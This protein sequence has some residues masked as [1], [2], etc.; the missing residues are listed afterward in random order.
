MKIINNILI[1]AFLLSGTAWAG[2][3]I[4]KQHQFYIEKPYGWSEVA[5]NKS[6][7]FSIG[8][9]AHN[10]EMGIIL[11]PLSGFGQMRMNQFSNH[12]MSGLYENSTVFKTYKNKLSKAGEVEFWEMS[13][14]ESGKDIY[15]IWAWKVNGMYYMM[16]GKSHDHDQKNLSVAM[17]NIFT[18]FF[19]TAQVKNDGYS[20]TAGR[21]SGRSHYVNSTEFRLD[22]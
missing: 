18:Q 12:I 21:S 14:Q 1:A 17:K 11:M 10:H 5:D 19:K 16:M 2:S 7:I 13:F 4:D 20:E 22:R 9:T 6:I 3:Y 15:D 8:N